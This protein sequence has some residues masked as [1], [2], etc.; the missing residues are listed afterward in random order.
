VEVSGIIGRVVV[1]TD[2]ARAGE[3]LPGRTLLAPRSG[4]LAD[5][6]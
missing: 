1:G 4:L 5:L 6:G 3:S 2:R